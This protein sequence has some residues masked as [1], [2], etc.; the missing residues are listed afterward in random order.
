MPISVHKL[1]GTAARGLLIAAAVCIAL[2]SL[3]SA[4]WL[5]ANTIASRAVYKE[6]AELGTILGPSDPQ[7]HLV[8]AALLEKTFF[9]EDL[10]RSIGE[11]ERAVAL[12]PADY[13]LW[14]ELGRARARVGD[15]PG[16]E[17]ALRRSLELA[18]NYS[19]VNWTLGNFLL[20]QNKTAE[21]FDR[22]RRAADSDRQY[23]N[24][25]ITNAW[26]VFD[27]DLQR[28]RELAG[29][30]RDLRVSLATLLASEKRFVEA[31]EIWNSLPEADR[32]GELKSNGDA[33]FREM[34]AAKHYRDAV[35]M[36]GGRFVAGTLSNG[37]FESPISIQS[38]SEFEWRI[39]AGSDSQIAVDSGQKRE[40]GVS[41]VMLFN[42]SDGKSVSGISQTVAVEPGKSYVLRGFYHS[43]LKATTTLKWVVSNA[44]DGKS[45]GE[46][47]PLEARVEW[48]EFSLPFSVPVSADGVVVGL[49]RADCRSTICPIS[50]RVWFDALSI[51][52]AGK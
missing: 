49:N 39:A 25:A 17:T 52:E 44:V 35:S 15:S 33:I 40:G 45:L 14:L 7:T 5:I 46:T 20:R 27:G 3:T 4:R 47:T 10:T 43:D 36:S 48:K 32:V 8:N 16:A 9:P 11:Y 29:D 23:A 22:I 31:L 38:P 18:P 26:Q 37:G 41:L 13:V 34:L 1:S 19:S 30:S 42:S 2:A 6:I 50:G 28:V 24:P 21:A 12:S 51:S